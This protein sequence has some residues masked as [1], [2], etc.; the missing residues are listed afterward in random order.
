M[1]FTHTQAENEVTVDCPYASSS[2][3]FLDSEIRDDK[4]LF[5]LVE[6]CLRHK[7]QND[8]YDRT[9]TNVGEATFNDLLRALFDKMQQQGL[10]R[11][12]SNGDLYSHDFFEGPYA[13]VKRY[14]AKE[15]VDD[16]Y[17][18]P[19][20]FGI[21]GT[22]K[23]THVKNLTDYVKSTPSHQ[24]IFLENFSDHFGFNDGLLNTRTNTFI[25]ALDSGGR[26]IMTRKYF[27]ISHT[28][29]ETMATPHFDAFLTI[30]FGPIDGPE[31]NLTLR[32]N[33]L[34]AIGSLMF[35]ITKQY[36]TRPVAY[37]FVTPDMCSPQQ[38]IL[39]KLFEALSRPSDE[40]T[41][42]DNRTDI[43]CF[44]RSAIDPYHP[45]LT[46]PNSNTTP[47]VFITQNESP[48]RCDT[49]LVDICVKGECANLAANDTWIKQEA[50]AIAKRIVV[51]YQSVDTSFAQD[52]NL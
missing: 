13:F 19:F 49:K 48:R 1:L 41:P 12:R 45:F 9:F 39:W 5:K 10:Y 42:Q 30:Q 28:D 25:S 31:F 17:N 22:L 46:L 4:G 27:N 23:L 2:D 14:S 24:S 38:K 11:D 15:L 8:L 6:T 40:R 20:Q 3:R 47:F 51:T 34:K 16:L 29:A 35:P 44:M 26:K 50:P 43:V 52:D 36:D 18:H 32:N 21:V 7:Q 33:F 37:N